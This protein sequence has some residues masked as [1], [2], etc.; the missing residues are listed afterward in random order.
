MQAVCGAQ[1]PGAHRYTTVL[2][3]EIDRAIDP[4]VLMPSNAWHAASRRKTV[5][6]RASLALQLQLLGSR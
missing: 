1:L 3:P 5:W 6:I 2:P 4:N